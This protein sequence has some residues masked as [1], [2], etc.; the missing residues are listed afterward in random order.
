MSHPPAL[1]RWLSPGHYG[2]SRLASRHVGRSGPS[3]T[4][5][6]PPAQRAGTG[7]GSTRIA[8]SRFGPMVLAVS[9]PKQDA[10]FWIVIRCRRGALQARSTLGRYH[11]LAEALGYDKFDVSGRRRTI[12]LARHSDRL[13]GLSVLLCLLGLSH[14]GV[15]D[16]LT[17]PE[18]LQRRIT[19]WR[20]VQAAGKKVRELRCS[21]Q[22]H[23]G[24]VRREASS[25]AA[26]VCAGAWS[27]FDSPG[28]FIASPRALAQ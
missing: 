21:P 12:S 5:A 28:F 24:L 14:R 23:S 22:N 10:S 8:G 13:K 11:A 20:N 26:A 4:I 19:V 7:S 16:L 15:E 18:C 25:T 27:T 17:A 1:L 6:S 2:T 3:R 9:V